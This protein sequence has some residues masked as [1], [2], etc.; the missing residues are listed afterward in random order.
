METLYMHDLSLYC[1]QVNKVFFYGFL[2]FK[3]EHLQFSFIVLKSMFS[4]IED[5]TYS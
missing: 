3:L 2:S 1:S 4:K 5:E